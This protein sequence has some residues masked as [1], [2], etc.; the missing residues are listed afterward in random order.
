MSAAVVNVV[1]TPPQFTP[2][3][4]V[5]FGLGTTTIDTN[6]SFTDFDEELYG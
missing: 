4:G 1:Q 3:T 6:Q 2:H 5:P